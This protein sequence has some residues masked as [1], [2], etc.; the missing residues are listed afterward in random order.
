MVIMHKSFQIRF[1]R[2]ILCTTN[3]FAHATPMAPHLLCI[4]GT[5]GLSGRNAECLIAAITSRIIKFRMSEIGKILP[6]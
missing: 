4:P 3:D 5:D 1:S 2:Y 6:I